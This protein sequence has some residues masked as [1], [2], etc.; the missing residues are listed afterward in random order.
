VIGLLH[1]ICD[2][3]RATARRRRWPHDQALGR[4]AEDMAH[5]L[6]RRSGFTVVARNYRPRNGPGEIDLIAWQRDT[7]VF[8][9][10]KSRT[11][12][13]FG[14]P[15]RAVG[16]QKRE[17]LVRSAF[18]Y[19]RRAGVPADRIRFDVVNVVF[20]DPPAIDRIE[21]AFRPAPPMYYNT[22]SP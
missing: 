19:A 5:R 6:L 15:D 3:L 18:E 8:V 1:R 20:S 16:R 22:F 2:R 13:E 17:T 4:R 10:V 9:E 14:T 11:T 21:N 12:D 7:L